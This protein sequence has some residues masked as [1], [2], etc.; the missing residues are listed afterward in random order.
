MWA[1]IRS[2]YGTKLAIGYAVTGGFVA[3][4][5]FLTGSVAATVLATASGLLALGSITG[6]ATLAAAKEVEREAQRVAN[7][8]LDRAIETQRT[9]EVGGIYAAIDAMRVS[10]SERIEELDAA[11]ADAE[12]TSDEAT[13][14]AEDYQRI[15]ERYAETM[16][17]AAEGDLT[18]RIDVDTEHESMT[19]I[20]REF[21]ATME[22]LQSALADFSVFAAD[23][24]DDVGEMQSRGQAASGRST[25]R[26]TPQ[27]TSASGRSPSG[28]RSRLSPRTSTR[29]RR[30]PRR[31]PRRSTIWPSRATA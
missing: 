28:R 31:W 11:R 12:R 1:L 20:G 15:A 2:R 13:A 27:T 14:L 22:Q 4:V 23:I 17:Q 8:D 5:G 9:D 6:T 7:G 26:S 21:N 3:A 29:S 25:V 16:Q 10:L 18:Q 24:S 19:T 30:P